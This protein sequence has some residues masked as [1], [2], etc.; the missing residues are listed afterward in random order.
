MTNRQMKLK[1]RLMK[2]RTRAKKVI[3]FRLLGT[4][5]QYRTHL[6]PVLSIRSGILA[7]EG[8]CP[9]CVLHGE[10][11]ANHSRG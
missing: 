8:K 7:R 11:K 6:I 5:V 3:R 10:L 2:Q 9:I 4:P 1:R